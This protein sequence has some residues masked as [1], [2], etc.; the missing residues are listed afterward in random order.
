M[1]GFPY[2]VT[3]A[4]FQRS[5]INT[6]TVNAAIL[7][8]PRNIDILGISFVSLCSVLAVIGDRFPV[9]YFKTIVSH[10]M[11][12]PQYA[13]VVYIFT[14]TLPLSILRKCWNSR[15]SPTAKPGLQNT[16]QGALFRYA[17]LSV[18]FSLVFGCL[19]TFSIAK[20]YWRGIWKWPEWMQRYFVVQNP[21]LLSRDGAQFCDVWTKARGLQAGNQSQDHPTSN[22]KAR[23]LGRHAAVFCVHFVLLLSA[24][25]LLSKKE[26]RVV[27]IIFHCSPAAQSLRCRMLPIKTLEQRNLKLSIFC[28]TLFPFSLSHS[29]SG[30]MR[31]KAKQGDTVR[32]CIASQCLSL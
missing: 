19:K 31:W 13:K 10:S 2:L 26:T 18:I 14:S 11:Y 28:S 6:L 7:L 16:E 24:A 25:F 9:F 5:C 12:G 21:A 29:C 30:W 23:A 32:H 22:Q 4:R 20:A 15:S 17:F 3:A 8:R 27:I 1:F